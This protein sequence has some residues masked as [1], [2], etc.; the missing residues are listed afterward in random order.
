MTDE[1]DSLTETESQQSQVE[2]AAGAVHFWRGKRLLWSFINSAAFE[3]LSVFGRGVTSNI[4]AAATIVYLAL[5]QSDADI[6]RIDAAHDQQSI[7]QLRREIA[8]W[9]DAEGLTMNNADGLECSRVADAIWLDTQRSRFEPI[10]EHSGKKKGLDQAQ[11]TARITSPKSR[12]R[13][14]AA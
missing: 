12:P 1:L 7:K 3:R 10:I 6:D 9:A 4:E 5:Q 14:K 8:K 11:A 13:S 2:A